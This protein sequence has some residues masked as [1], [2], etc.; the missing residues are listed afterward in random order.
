M[1]VVLEV[2]NLVQ[3]RRNLNRNSDPPL[4]VDDLVNLLRQASLTLG[5]HAQQIAETGVRIDGLRQEVAGSRLGNLQSINRDMS[6][7]HDL[8]A[9][10][11]SLC[12]PL[13]SNEKWERRLKELSHD[14]DLAFDGQR[15]FAERA[16]A[17]AKDPKRVFERWKDPPLTPFEKF[18][19]IKK[20]FGQRD[21]FG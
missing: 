16:R 2:D 7:F 10:I 15:A 21:G 12:A 6:N 20:A 19:Q 13:T 11:D 3:K 8:M 5:N 14:S 4:N 9:I 17:E 1:E 18:N